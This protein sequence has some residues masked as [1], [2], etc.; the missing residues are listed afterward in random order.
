MAGPIFWQP[1]GKGHQCYNILQT[2]Q[3]KNNNQ[4]WYILANSM[5]LLFHFSPIL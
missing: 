1:F 4:C 2:K 5:S 3:E